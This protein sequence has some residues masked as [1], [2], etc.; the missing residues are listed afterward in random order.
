V[1]YPATAITATASAAMVRAATAPDSVVSSSSPSMYSPNLDGLRSPAVSEPGQ[2][3]GA[4]PVGR[5]GRPAPG[6]AG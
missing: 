4:G 3:G 2:V 5:L 6:A 1:G